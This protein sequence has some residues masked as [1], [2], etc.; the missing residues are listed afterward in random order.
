MTKKERMWYTSLIGCKKKEL[1]DEYER[2]KVAFIYFAS[3]KHKYSSS[4]YI[5]SSKWERS[6]DLRKMVSKVENKRCDGIVKKKE[7][8]RE[9]H[10]KK[11]KSR[12]GKRKS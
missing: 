2:R 8:E 7:G 4:A 1:K 10:G 9:K 5:G 11:L 12:M 6:E 3:S